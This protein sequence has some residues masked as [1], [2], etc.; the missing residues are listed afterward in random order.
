VKKKKEPNIETSDLPEEIANE[1]Y[2]AI[3]KYFRKRNSKYMARRWKDFAEGYR[4]AR[5]DNSKVLVEELESDRNKYQAHLESLQKRLL[6]ER[7][8][9]TNAE[10]RAWDKYKSRMDQMK[11][12]IQEHCMTIHKLKSELNIKE[13]ALVS[14]GVKLQERLEL[15]NEKRNF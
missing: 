1:L 12:L 15:K 3:R 4:A 9:N 6:E 11:D 2:K 5:L 10:A 14:I 7:Q 13:Q 8:I